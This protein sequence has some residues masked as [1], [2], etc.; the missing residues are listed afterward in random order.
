VDVGYCGAN[1]LLPVGT[2]TINETPVAHVTLRSVSGTSGATQSGNSASVTVPYN[3]INIVTFDNEINT[4]TFKV[5]KAETSSDAG[6]QNTAFDLTYSYDYNGETI[7]G[8][9]SA[10]EPGQCTLPI[11]NVPV[12]NSNL[13][14]VYIFVTEET[15]SVPNIGLFNVDVV[16]SDSVVKSPAPPTHLVSTPGGSAATLELTSLEGI[17]D[18]TFVNG[19][20]IVGG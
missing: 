18:V 14:P 13:T 5:C 12:L 4:G 10:L 9:V 3:N 8:P 20:D 16:G 17:T 15:T 11:D 2:A 19:I 7:N 1:Q 6:L